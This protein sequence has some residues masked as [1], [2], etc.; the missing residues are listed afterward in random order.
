MN[1]AKLVFA[2]YAM[3]MN[4]VAGSTFLIGAQRFAASGNNAV[5]G[6]LTLA[7]WSGT[8]SIGSLIIGRFMPSGGDVLPV[9]HGDHCGGRPGLCGG[10]A[11]QYAVFLDFPGR[12]GFCFLL[13][14]LSG[15]DPRIRSRSPAWNRPGGGALFIQ[16]EFRRGDR[17]VSGRHA[18]E[19]LSGVRLADRLRD[20]CGIGVG[21]YLQYSSVAA[22]SPGA[23]ENIPGNGRDGCRFAPR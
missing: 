15:P 20:Q 11:A 1:S 8:Y 5:Q 18:L 4:I 9:G 13:H 21:D 3:A 10:A 22:Q 17:P 7:I 12:G 2:L 6:A 14:A 19:S 23:A 16:L